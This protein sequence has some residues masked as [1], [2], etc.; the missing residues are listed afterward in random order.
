MRCFR[1]L[2]AYK[3]FGNIVFGAPKLSDAPMAQKLQLPCGRCTGCRL[4]QSRQW[5]A[6]I[7]ME[8]Q[9]HDESCFITLT[10]DDDHL[11]AFNS[12]DKKHLTDFFKRLRKALDPVKVRYFAVGEY[13]EKTKR[14]HYHIILFG[15]S[16][17]DKKLYRQRSNPLYESSILSKAWPYGFANFGAVSFESAA[18]CARYCLKKVNRQDEDFEVACDV[19]TGEVIYRVKE[20]SVM[21]RRPGI[22]A[23]WYDVFGG[24]TRRTDFVVMRGKAMK[25]PRY[26]DKLFEKYDSEDFFRVKKKRSLDLD[27]GHSTLEEYLG[28]REAEHAKVL[29]QSALVRR[30]LDE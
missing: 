28:L 22:G 27:S 26:F 14:P 29:L 12:L 1:P 9:L 21:S 24:D 6:R 7:M 25:P 15:T 3:S 10:Y 16:F 17:P 8:N 2:Q 23:L 20:F 4:E 30:K 19:S 13:G 11:P 18:Y 5:A